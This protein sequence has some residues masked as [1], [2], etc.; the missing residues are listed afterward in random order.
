MPGPVVSIAP[1]DKLNLFKLKSTLVYGFFVKRVF[2]RLN[3]NYKR[4]YFSIYYE[5]VFVLYLY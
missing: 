2:Y 5:A 3:R 4:S 1:R